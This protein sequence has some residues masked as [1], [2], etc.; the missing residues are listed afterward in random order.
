MSASRS[1]AIFALGLLIWNLIGVAAFILQYTADLAAL[2]KSDPYTARIFAGMPG[3]AWAAYAVAVGAGTLGA[4]M[5]L[6]RKR[7]AVPLFALSVI[8]VVVQ[9]GYSF[10]GTDLLAVKGAGA[11]A[12]PAV[13]LVIAVG[14]LLYAQGLQ[15]KGVLR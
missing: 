8:G 13:I 5:L 6:M 1:F 14:Q 2:A 11:A 12:F 7:V 4:T 9:F 10:L 15:A 3:W